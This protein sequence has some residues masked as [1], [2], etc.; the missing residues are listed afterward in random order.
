MY[1][2]NS[3]FEYDEMIKHIYS[4]CGTENNEIVLYKIRRATSIQGIFEKIEEKKKKLI[5]SVKT[6]KSKIYFII[7]Y[8][9]IFIVICLGLSGVGKTSLIKT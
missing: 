8:L 6:I 3:T 2:C 9:F 7:L 4:K 1:K 5:E